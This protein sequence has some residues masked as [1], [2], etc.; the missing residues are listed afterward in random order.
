MHDKL[1]ISPPIVMG[2]YDRP[3]WDS[4]AQRAMRLQKCK[5]C[6]TFRYP[7]GPTCG[8]CLSVDFEWHAI[9]G[10]AIIWSWVVFHRQYLEAYP[11]PY[12]VIS[13]Q[14]EEG[15]L[16]VSNLEGPEPTGSW[17]GQA[18]EICYITLNGGVVLPRFRLIQ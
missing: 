11:P 1:P 5:Q 18:V 12:N 14:L 9:S 16:M 17:I 4:I 10:K 15:P 7:P 2:L 13:V 3:M 8:S 6:G